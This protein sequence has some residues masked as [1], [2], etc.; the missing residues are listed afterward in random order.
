MVKNGHFY[1][2]Y[3][4]NVLKMFKNVPFSTKNTREFLIKNAQKWPIS[5]KYPKNLP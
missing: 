1:R 4:K 2:K 3:P 5:R